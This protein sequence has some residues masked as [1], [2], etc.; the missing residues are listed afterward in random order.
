MRNALMLC[1][2]AVGCSA[3]VA[4]DDI[5]FEIRKLAHDLNEGIDI[6]DFNKD[7]KPD[8]VAGRMWYPN[9]DFV[10]H[11]VRDIAD[12]NGYVTS[13]GDHTIDIDNDGYI[14]VLSG[15]FMDTKVFWYRNPGPDGLTRGLR[16]K[17][18]L[19][20]DTGAVHNEAAYLHDIDGDHAPEWITNDWTDKAPL[21]AHQ[22]KRNDKG[23]I[24]AAKVTLGPNGH[25]HGIGFGDLNGDGRQDVLVGTGW[26]EQ[27]KADPMSKTWIYHPVWKMKACCP[28]QV[29]DVDGDG[30]NDLIWSNGHDYGIYWWRQLEPSADDELQWEKHEI[31]KSYSQAHALHLADLDN[32]GRPE[33]ITGKRVWAHNGKDPGGNEPPCIYYYTISPDGK[34]TRHTINEG[35]IGIGLQ[36]RTADFNGDGRL[37]IAVAGKSGTYLLLNKGR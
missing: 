11:P 37:D 4:G 17:Q 14:D 22:L 30:R 25:G 12:W 31:D 19:L 28:M 7:G 9:P 21:I 6:A 32:D 18:N 35:Q 24:T 10:P 26:Y 13:H 23:L 36:I 3:A 27:P 1:L 33:L 34:F 5:Q 29:F 16:W 20:V 8:I 15:A 2:L